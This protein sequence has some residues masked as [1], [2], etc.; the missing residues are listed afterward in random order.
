MSKAARPLEVLHELRDRAIDRKPQMADGMYKQH[1][2]RADG[3][4][5]HEAQ[6]AQ[7]RRREAISQR[8]HRRAS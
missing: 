6:F 4:L 3:Q 1:P 8:W 5:M 7:D 2:V